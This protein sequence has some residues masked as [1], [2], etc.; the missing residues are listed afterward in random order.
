M[1][2]ALIFGALL[3]LLF[4]NCGKKQ[5]NTDAD[6]AEV[7]EV[8]FEDFVGEPEY[9]S[10]ATDDAN[11]LRH[12]FR[13]DDWY[14][15][16]DSIKAQYTLLGFVITGNGD[17]FIAPLGIE[18]GEYTQAEAKAKF[19]DRLPTFDQAQMLKDHNLAEG[20]E[21]ILKTEYPF[22]DSNLY[23]YGSK[24]F[25]TSSEDYKGLTL[26]FSVYS[27]D[28]RWNSTN[29]LPVY[30][31]LPLNTDDPRVAKYANG[32]KSYPSD[33]SL[34]AEKDGKRYYF[35][36]NV[37]NEVNDSTYTPIGIL[38]M[39]E[40]GA[41]IFPLQWDDELVTWEEAMERT[42]G[43]LP[44]PLQEKII[45]NCDYTHHVTGNAFKE[46]GFDI[47]PQQSFWLQKRGQGWYNPEDSIPVS[48]AP[49]IE[50]FRPD[51]GYAK[52]LTLIE[53]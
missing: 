23:K 27:Y 37:W 2:K 25:W 33:L 20:Y 42:G 13:A 19:G 22:S 8:K 12:Y 43:K 6:A 29:K 44:T 11:G 16:S 17:S 40:A 48:F 52:I 28:S 3:A 49:F 10:V 51:G 47:D 18:E 5:D 21:R 36:K 53:F 1:K 32:P 4:T 31:I 41:V 7:N 35:K 15:M 38:C 30:T 39:K 46:F 9:M 34:V 45:M 26:D 24:R 50:G 14:K